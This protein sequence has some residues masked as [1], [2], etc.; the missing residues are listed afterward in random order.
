MAIFK[1]FKATDITNAF[2]LNA[3]ATAFITIIAIEVRDYIKKNFHKKWQILGFE[4]I[5]AFI[6]AIT[7]YFLLYIL[8]GFG[9]GF[10]AVKHPKF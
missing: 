6:T 3:M 1:H 5:A 4:F 8:F 10:I 2:I 9:G 7:V